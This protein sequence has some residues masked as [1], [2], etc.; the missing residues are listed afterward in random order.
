[1]LSAAQRNHI[2]LA[3]RMLKRDWQ[4]GHLNVLVM[5][6][7]V[8]VSTHATI[9]FISERIQNSMLVQASAL[10]GGDL[11]IRSPAPSD[12]AWLEMAGQRNIRHAQTLEF[13]S[14]VLAGDAMQLAAVKA[15]TDEY[16]LKTPLKVSDAPFAP[17]QAVTH[18]PNPGKVWLEQRMLTALS[19]KIGDTVEVGDATLSVEKVLLFEPDRSGNFYSFVP[20][21]LMHWDDIDATGVI[22]PGSRLDYYAQFAGDTATILALQDDIKPQLQPGQS[23]L[24]I[25]SQQRSISSALQRAEGYLQ[26]ASLMAILLAAVAIAMGAHFFS[27]Q[28]FDTA[29]LLR[30]FGLSSRQIMQLFIIQLIVLALLAGLIGSAVGWSLHFVAVTMLGELLPA[31]T[32]LPGPQ[33][34]FTGILLALVILPGFALPS[35]TQLQRTPPLRVLRRDLAPQPLSQ[36]AS[37]GSSALLVALLMLWYARDPILIAAIFAGAVAGW[38]VATLLTDLFMRALLVISRF[39]PL[40]VQAGLRNLARRRNGTRIQLLGFGLTGMAMLMVILVR[41]ELISTWEDQL[42]E[43]APNH[44]VLN[45]LPEQASAFT[46]FLHANSIVSQPLYPVI[47][48]RLT[49]INEGAVIQAVSKEKQAEGEF[50]A[51]EA[52]NRE[53]NLTFAPDIPSDNVIVEGGWWD[54][55]VASAEKQISIEQKLAQKLNVKLGDKLTFFVANQ[56]F[57]ARVASIRTVKWESFQPNF[58]I[59]FHPGDLDEMPTT[60]LT[61]FYLS[62]H[63]KTLLKDLVQQFPAVSV[64]EVDAILARVKGILAQVSA[65]VEFILLFV[66]AAG[67]TITLA[68]LITTMPERYRE[69]ALMRTLGATGRQLR[70]QQWSEFFAIGFLAGIVAAGG[71]ELARF[72]VYWKIFNLPYTPALWIWIIMP[73]LFG[74][75]IGLAGHWSSRKILGQSPLILLRDS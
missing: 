14:V 62:A 51:P 30:C 48:G 49:H 34:L 32:P 26:L 66:L 68:T 65:A 24:S 18:G 17:E 28:H 19:V 70:L 10:L 39:S 56:T 53:L 40:S 31:N 12:P 57:S 73:P 69:G 21:V 47:R 54:T 11:V 42:P 38:L 63:Q 67:L 2:A 44:F 22:Q 3:L 13:S 25:H 6:L 59:I 33:P 60:Y 15:V 43:Q 64:L 75:L 20:R 71:C 46:Q 27:R 1:M 9:G 74:V 72:G 16:P 45:I 55:T 37:Y 29:A 8:A 50:D 52:L 7:L 4:S 41:T 5:A 58:Y 23:I 36:L 61:S 35:L